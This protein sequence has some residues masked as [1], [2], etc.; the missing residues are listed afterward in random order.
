MNLS[1]ILQVKVF[2]YVN[3]CERKSQ[4]SQS[5]LYNIKMTVNSLCAIF[6]DIFYEYF[7][8]NCCVL[9]RYALFLLYLFIYSILSNVRCLV[10]LYI[11]M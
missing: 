10:S 7:M 8:I 11:P 3:K 5:T 2:I 4:E 1:I 9:N 6:C